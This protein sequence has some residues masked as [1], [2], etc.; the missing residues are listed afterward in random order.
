MIDGV[1]ELNY[2]ISQ[3]YARKNE[4]SFKYGMYKKEKKITAKQLR[5]V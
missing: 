5:C 3:N 4:N 2:R 1:F